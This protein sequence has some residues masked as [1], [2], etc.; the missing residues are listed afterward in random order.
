MKTIFSDLPGLWADVLRPITT[1]EQINGK[2]V[3]DVLAGVG[4]PFPDLEL[5]WVKKVQSLPPGEQVKEVVAELKRRNPGFDREVKHH[6]QNG[7]VTSLAITSDALTDLSPVRPLAGLQK[8]ECWGTGPGAGNNLADLSPLK[9]MKLKHLSFAFTQVADLSPLESMPLETLGIITSP[10]V[11][12]S[13]LRGAS[14]INLACFD[15]FV[16]DLSPLRGMPIDFL[17]VHLNQVTDHSPLRGM[18]LAHLRCDFLPERDGDDLRSIKT[19]R[20]I[21]G[22]PAVEFW[23][24]VDAAKSPFPPLDR[25]WLKKVQ[26]L[27]PQERIQEVVALL[28]QRNP[29]FDGKVAYKFHH[30]FINDLRLSTDQVTDL[31]P[32][33][34]LQRIYHLNVGGSGPRKGRLV[35]LSPLYWLSIVVLE[36]S[37]NP[38]TDLSPL[39]GMPLEV[40]NLHR[41]A[42]RDLSP[43]R[44]SRLSS[45]GIEGA[46]APDLTPLKDLPLLKALSCDLQSQRDAAILR[47]IKTLETINGK[48]AKDVL[49]GTA[50]P[51]PSLDPAWVKKLQSL[52]SEEQVKEVAVELKRRNPGFDGKVEWTIENGAVSNLVFVTDAVTDISPVRVLTGLNGLACT[53]SAVGAAGNGKLAD[54]SPLNGLPLTRFDCSYNAIEDLSPLRGM[55]LTSLDCQSS[56]VRD[57]S[58]LKGMPL[59]LINCANTKV[60][61]LSPLSNAP[62]K[63]LHCAGSAVSDLTPLKGMRLTTVWCGFTQVSDLAPLRGMPLTMIACSETPISDLSPLVDAPLNSIVCSFNPWRDTE[64]L[65]SIKTLVRINDKPAADFWKQVDAERKKFDEWAGKVAKLPP[66]EQV[67]EVATELKRR[68]PEFDGKVNPVL[69]N[70]GAVEHFGFNAIEVTDLSP[71]R[72]LAGVKVLICVNGD[73]ARRFLNEKRPPAKLADLWPL[74]GLKLVQLEIQGTQ[75]ADLRPLQGM[76]L[77]SLRIDQ[78]AVTNL[79]PLTYVPL[80][81]L[82]LDIQPG[83]DAMLL[84]TIKTLEQIN[85]KPAADLLK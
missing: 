84:R 17:E 44:G 35:D 72:A 53:G 27:G 50:K 76:P 7:V 25:A 20:N 73:P 46:P 16:K 74:Q 43:L 57:L 19:L 79:A 77:R 10:V 4:K 59:E 63:F 75:V 24:A 11:D 5:A 15:T 68:N 21:N 12:L 82:W 37:D 26:T 66:E 56:V 55:R 1:L 67:K 22:K 62:L 54:L 23:K 61:D 40:L 48:P 65:R 34:A 78:S 9:G 2:P 29:G 42:V 69:V 41:T 47:S 64:L 38:V 83:R 39:Q 70:N 52:P 49:V 28:Q 31:T 81:A 13:P 30:G 51:F 18:P 58:P 80:N 8:L 45:L 3:K 71:V 32:V 85:G 36:C 14:L 33:R 6:V 60:A